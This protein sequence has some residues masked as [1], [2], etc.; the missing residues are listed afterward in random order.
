MK[1]IEEKGMSAAIKL[2]KVRGYEIIDN[3]DEFI[4]AKHDDTLV[5]I[6]VKTKQQGDSLPTETTERL[7]K[8]ALKKLPTLEDT[9]TPVRLD[10]ISITA[11]SSDRCLIKHHIAVNAGATEVVKN[12][13]SFLEKKI[14]ALYKLG[15]IKEVA[16][17][18]LMECINQMNM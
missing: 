17:N 9:D 16:Y 10:A 8:Y 7:E 14:E 15:E 5:F 6:M 1:T 4:T 11:F 3:D 18:E 12:D 2:L 13:L